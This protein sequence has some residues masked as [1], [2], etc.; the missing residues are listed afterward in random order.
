VALAG[1]EFVGERGVEGA[2]HLDVLVL[3]RG[4]AGPIVVVDLAG[5]G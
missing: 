3:Q 4:E 2:E 1:G 5:F